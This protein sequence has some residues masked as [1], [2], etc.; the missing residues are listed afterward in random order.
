MNVG[1]SVNQINEGGGLLDPM[2]ADE[3]GYKNKLS[4]K[5][6]ASSI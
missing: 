3:E 6:L 2:N 4:Y 1:V 5:T